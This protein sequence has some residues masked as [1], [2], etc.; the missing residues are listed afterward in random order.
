MHL[1][2]EACSSIQRCH[3]EFDCYQHGK[4]TIR[5]CRADAKP[6]GGRDEGGHAISAIQRDICAV[7]FDESGEEAIRS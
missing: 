4:R 3:W 1:D 7:Q 5:K 6:R 2:M